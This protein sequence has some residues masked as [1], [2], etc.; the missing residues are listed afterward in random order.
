M[1]RRD[2]LKKTGLAA[3]GAIAAPYILPTGRL[4]A[5]TGA[6]PLSNHVV[7]VMFAGG[8]R[9]QESIGQTYLEGSQMAYA[10]SMAQPELNVNGN[11][12]SNMLTGAAPTSKIVYGKGSG[13]QNPIQP[14]LSQTL[15]QQ[16]TLFSQMT[17]SSVGHYGGLNVLIQ[18]NTFS[19]QGL[20]QRPVNPTIFEYIRRHGGNVDFPASKIWFVGNG[21]GNSIPLLNYSEHPQYG[22]KYG[23]NFFA[24]TITFGPKG[25]TYLKD[26]KV[27]HPQEQ[28]APMYEMKYFLDNSFANV[29]RTLPSIG[30]TEDEKDQIRQFMKTMFQKTAAG[31]IAFPPE[32]AIAG[33][34]DTATIGY[35]CEVLKEFKPKLTVVN[36]D[37]VDACHTGFTEYLKALHR[38]DHAVGHLWNFIQ[39]DS[40]MAGNTT[41]IAVPDCGRDA[42]PNAIKDSQNDFFGYDHSD[43]NAANVFCIMAGAG[44]PVN[45]HVNNTNNPAFASQWV[46]AD[47]V[48]TIAD[49]LGLKADVMGAN[50]LMAGAGSLL[51]KI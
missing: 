28:L 40:V 11:I 10:P 24:P 35:A 13:G 1:K 49:L 44:V 32:H 48:P 18:G 8:V 25:N 33:N 42:T 46:T 15:Q 21:I 36:L 50:M 26:A 39:S 3:A 30:N 34:K 16:G 37:A 9:W 43:A 5:S 2:F 27:Y 38:A 45:M 41:I 19:S 14:L 20:K 31:T 23:A 6:T 22:T 12:M 51:D 7:L 4:F 47:I 29:G 17:C